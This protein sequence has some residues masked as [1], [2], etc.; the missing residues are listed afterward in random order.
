MRCLNN[1]SQNGF[2]ARA[3][4]ETGLRNILSWRSRASLLSREQSE[5][6]FHLRSGANKDA[7]LFLVFLGVAAVIP[8]YWLYNYYALVDVIDWK[9]ALYLSASLVLTGMYIAF[10]ARE[11]ISAGRSHVRIDMGILKRPLTIRWSEKPALKLTLNADESG[12]AYF[13]ELKLIDGRREYSMK[14]LPFASC[15]LRRIG[16]QIA[17]MLQCPFIECDNT[18]VTTVIDRAGMETPFVQR[19]RKI[20]DDSPH[21]WKKPEHSSMVISGNDCSFHAVWSMRTRGLLAE[22]TVLSSFLFAATCLHLAQGGPSFWE[23][24]LSRGDYL[25]YYAEGVVLALTSLYLAGL[26]MH[27]SADSGFISYSETLLGVVLR[28]KTLAIE[29]LEDIRVSTAPGKAMIHMFSGQKSIVAAVSGE[30]DARWLDCM[31]RQFL[32]GTLQAADPGFPVNQAGC[33]NAE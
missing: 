13:W 33:M 20:A 28:K 5:R 7:G 21:V 17:M 25:A 18:G 32:G 31:L 4:F 19:I 8:L 1:D 22:M 29:S 16:R 23:Q 10:L 26:R 27:I 30:Q 15:E 11:S 3:F 9:P 2:E 14:R 12:M 24:C 6:V